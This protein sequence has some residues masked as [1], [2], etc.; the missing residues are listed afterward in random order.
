MFLLA[1]QADAPTHACNLEFLALGGGA[2]VRNVRVVRG[3][4]MERQ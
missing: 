3:G 1:P 4:R 2:A